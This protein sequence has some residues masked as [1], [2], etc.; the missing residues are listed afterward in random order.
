M[1]TYL[2]G[3]NNYSGVHVE[4]LKDSVYD[5]KKL[6]KKDMHII[7]ENKDIDNDSNKES[8][9]S[10]LK[11]LSRVEDFS[12]KTFNFADDL[13]ISGFVPL[14]FA[15]DHS[16]AIASLSAS[17]K[18]YDDLG[19]VWVDAHAD[20]NTEETSPSGNIHGMPISFLL[21]YGRKS[22]SNLGGFSPKI[23][24]ENI[25]YLGLRSVDP[26]EKQLIS[27]LNIKAYYFD[28]IERIGLDEVLDQ[29]L[30]RLSHLK[31]I[32]ISFDFDSMNPE[33]FR[34]VS[35]PVAKGFNKKDI[36]TIF[37][38]LSNT[39]KIKAIDLVEYNKSRDRNRESL[40][41]ALKL[42]KFIE[43]L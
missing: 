20:I 3:V 39:N 13:I 31:N 43:D 16:I 25:V 1:K 11:N 21:G 8:I 34:A 30:N 6:Y 42:I 33:I 22:L 29:V 19:L 32:H 36:F 2:Y 5:I 14:C 12:Q 24:A 27:K 7:E 15:G 38:A 23:K 18:N 37:K 28:E 40:D 41:F 9:G 10:S 17:S 26:G 4:G 35:T